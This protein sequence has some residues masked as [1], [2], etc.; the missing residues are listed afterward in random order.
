MDLFYAFHFILENIDIPIENYVV[1]S[2]T[3]IL[4]CECYL[5]NDFQ[6]LFLWSKI[7]ETH[8][9]SC[10]MF[11]KLTYTLEYQWQ[12]NIE[13]SSIMLAGSIFLIL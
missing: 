8:G 1:V 6:V 10:H 11:F 12:V 2:N 9:L 4:L 7:Y 3:N 5:A 13:R